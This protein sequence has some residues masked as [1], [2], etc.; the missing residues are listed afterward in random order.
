VR[1]ESSNA[2]DRVV[3]VFR[4]FIANRLAHLHVGLA[5]QMVGG[6]E[7]GKVGHSLQ[8]PDDKIVETSSMLA[9]VALNLIVNEH[10][11]RGGGPARCCA[12]YWKNDR[13]RV[14]W[15]RLGFP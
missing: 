6:R 1:D 14:R 5:D 15:L 4:E 11:P 8:V 7:P 12:G 2:D 9:C 10:M 13:K 3:D